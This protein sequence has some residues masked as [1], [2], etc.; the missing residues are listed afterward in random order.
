M[1]REPLLHFLL[2]GAILFGLDALLSKH[3][4]S[5]AK[6][7][8][9]RGAVRAELAAQLERD[10]GAPPAPAELE[11]AVHGWVDDEILYREGVA[12]GFDRNDPALRSRI[13]RKM[14][15]VL[16]S[17]AIIPEPTEAE[18]AAWFRDNTERYADVARLDFTHV[19]L[20]GEDAAAL[21]RADAIL[22]QLRGGASPNG[23]GDRFSGG[24]RYRGR[25]LADLGLTFGEEFVRGLDEQPI[26]EWTLRRSRF[27]LH[28]VRVD[29]RTAARSADFERARA[30]VVHDWR[31]AA[32]DRAVASEMER[33]R[34]AWTVR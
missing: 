16:S 2:L 26:G 24:R 30:D 9:V 20:A 5:G 22:A 4:P 29:R 3:P 17:Q 7:I 15:G 18:L 10:R 12:R 8:V 11:R 32:K 27:G 19:F 14:L 28:L 33:L 13:A 25:A 31:E 34:A 6:E 1:L 23:L 21:R